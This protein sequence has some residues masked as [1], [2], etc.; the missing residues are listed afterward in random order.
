MGKAPPASWTRRWHS[1]ER[2]F[3]DDAFDLQIFCDT[4]DAVIRYTLDGSEPTEQRGSVYNPGA[5]S[6]S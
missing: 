3:Y 2:G 5:P 4:P 1:H 6:P